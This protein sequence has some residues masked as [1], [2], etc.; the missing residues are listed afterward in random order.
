MR[1]KICNNANYAKGLCKQHY[2]QQYYQDHKDKIMKYSKQWK[3]D[4]PDRANVPKTNRQKLEVREDGSTWL[5]L[6]G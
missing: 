4:N 1:C 3:L 5:N 2:Y 6:G